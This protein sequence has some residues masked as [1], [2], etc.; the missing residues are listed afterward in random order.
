MLNFQKL[1][2]EA[3]AHVQDKIQD[4]ILNECGLS[5]EPLYAPYGNGKFAVYKDLVLCLFQDKGVQYCSILGKFNPKDVE[6]AVKETLKKFHEITFCYL[7]EEKAKCIQKLF[8][9]AECST[10][11]NQN[12]YVYE[13]SDFI[14]LSGKAVQKK[15]SQYNQFV[16]NHNWSYAEIS[17]D[18]LKDCMEVT[19]DW[20]NRKNCSD[21]MYACEKE[22]I[23]SLLLN[24]HKYPC[25]GGI[26]YIDKIPQAF[27][28]CECVGDMVMG[29]HQKTRA[30]IKG[31]SF[32]IYIETM[33]NTFSNYK[34]FNF[35]PDLGIPGL[36]QFKRQ[37][38]PFERISK[39]S[40]KFTKSCNILTNPVAKAAELC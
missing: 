9:Y 40:L 21:C 36:R 8:P 3:F 35:G 32:A 6:T 14:N 31:L 37:F 17:E 13:I 5:M 20:C 19:E 1:E 30:A 23:R 10:D 26:I 18:N 11:E 15:R 29:Y 12:D 2:I 28:I 39:Y 25:K 24:W 22:I 7:T 16:Q 4:E 34:Y 27:L 38:K 33:K